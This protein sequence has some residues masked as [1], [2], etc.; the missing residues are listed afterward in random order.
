MTLLKM[1]RSVERPGMI[2]RAGIIHRVTPAIDHG[3]GDGNECPGSLNPIRLLLALS[4][5]L[6]RTCVEASMKQSQGH[7]PRRGPGRPINP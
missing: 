6:G 1:C 3:R 2:E 4:P 5:P 7:D